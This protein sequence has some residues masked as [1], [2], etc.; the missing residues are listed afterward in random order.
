M[1]S[2]GRDPANAEQRLL[3]SATI[4]NVSIAEPP[5]RLPPGPSDSVLVQTIRFRRGRQHYMPRMHERFGDVV[6]LKVAPGGPFVVLR[7]PDD[8]KEVFKG[9]PDVFH[10][11]EG[12]SILI[13]IVGRHSVLTLDAPSTSPRASG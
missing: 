9:A 8:I 5:D 12:N 3:S 13:P 7:N 4:S 11:G 6:T 1:S 2:V 10:A